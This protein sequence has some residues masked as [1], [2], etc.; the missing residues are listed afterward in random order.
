MFKTNQPLRRAL[1][2]IAFAAL[3]L[4]IALK[5]ERLGDA[6]SWVWGTLSCVTAGLC[7]AF[8]LNLIMVPLE[9]V[10]G[11]I[12][13]KHPKPKLTRVLSL[14]LTF[15]IALGLLALIFFSI[16]PS[17]REIAQTIAQYLPNSMN[18]LPAWLENTLARLGL[19]EQIIQNAKD[20]LQRLADYITD[21]VNDISSLADLAFSIT[22]GV[23]GGIVDVILTVA[24]S[25]YVLA[26]KEKLSH[27][28]SG[29]VR[30]YLPEKAQEIEHELSE[31]MYDKFS[32]FF[33]GQLIEA[34]ILGAACFVGMLIFRFPNAATISVLVGTSAIIPII[35]P[36]VGT[37]TGILLNLM[38][39]PINGLFF[40]IF[41]II[42]QQVEDNVV[43]PRIVGRQMNVP[44]ILVLA[45]VIVGA[46]VYGMM[47]IIA[48]VPLG[49]VLYELLKRHMSRRLSA[50]GEKGA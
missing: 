13:R 19:G 24:L 45:C 30:A 32:D 5:P 46:E 29:L 20:G 50:S 8:V 2:L 47:G 44:G 18:D 1:F 14:A 11:L 34:L 4:S 22:T 12:F 42:L 10:I 27:F 28:A 3:A 38:I 15:V 17:M 43:Y 36:W 48:A 41:I 23:F 6:F 33:K 7:L 9:R 35:G 40:A 49:A 25:V 31:L 39:S 16:L 37:I 26:D 21:Y